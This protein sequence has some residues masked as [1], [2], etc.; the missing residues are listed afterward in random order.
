MERTAVAN[1]NMIPNDD[2][3]A[4]L[5]V[6]KDILVIMLTSLTYFNAYIL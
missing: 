2:S 6:Y 5:F 1:A 4:F 3:P